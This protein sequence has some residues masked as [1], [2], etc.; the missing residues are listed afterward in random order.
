MSN[1][2]SA[3]RRFERMFPE[4]ANQE[5]LRVTNPKEYELHM[6]S[7]NSS[8]RS[9]SE[10]KLIAEIIYVFDKKGNLIEERTERV[11]Q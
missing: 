4:I 7:L 5:S 3:Y 10:G 8:S 1:L 2:H 11:N 9:S 6:K